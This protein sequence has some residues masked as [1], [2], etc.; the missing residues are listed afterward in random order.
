MVI[1]RFHERYISAVHMLSDCVWSLCKRAEIDVQR[2]LCSVVHP[3]ISFS[4]MMTCYSDSCNA[5]GGF[6]TVGN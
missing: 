3:F 2:S 4:G 6:P 1:N 5:L